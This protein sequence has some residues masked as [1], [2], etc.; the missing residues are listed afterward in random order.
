MKY[1]S[2]LTIWIVFSLSMFAQPVDPSK[3][4]APIKVACIGNSITYGSGISD[5]PRDSYPSQLARI[6]GDKWEVRNFGV[7]GRTL[8]KKGDFPFWN[9]EAY[10]QAKAFLPDVVIIKLGINDTKPQNW[11]YSGEFLPDFR[12]MVKELKA[13]SSNPEIYL[14]KPVPA[15]G[16]RWG[17]NDSIIVHGVIPPEENTYFLANKYI[18]LGGPRLF[19]PT[20]SGDKP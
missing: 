3:Y 20:R 10:A 14:C 2:L 5:R 19:T 9:E 17:I 4:S 11:K 12:S 18:R 8:L 15:Y 6:L 1:F 13:L 16:N 7:G